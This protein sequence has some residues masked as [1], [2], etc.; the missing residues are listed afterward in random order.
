MRVTDFEAKWSAWSGALQRRMGKSFGACSN[1][2]VSSGD[3]MH[4]QST[5]ASE[6]THACDGGQNQMERT[7]DMR[8]VRPMGASGVVGVSYIM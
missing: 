1:A 3:Y 5:S 6:K 7:E 4:K 8:G 2:D